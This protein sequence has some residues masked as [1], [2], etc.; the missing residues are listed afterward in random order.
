MH[1]IV[2]VVARAAIIGMWGCSAFAT[3]QGATPE[4]AAPPTFKPVKKG[5]AKAVSNVKP[6]LVEPF[7]VGSIRAPKL[8]VVHR[9]ETIM[10]VGI[11]V[12]S[13]GRKFVSYP[14][15]TDKGNW[16]LA[17][18]KDGKEVPYPSSGAFQMGHKNDPKTNLVS[19]Q[20]LI[21]DAQDRL[22]ILDT[23]TV[24]M[25]PVAP[26]SPKLVCI[27]TKTNT[28]T[29]TISFPE[30]VAPEGTYLN[31]LRIDGRRGEGEGIA[32]ITD[33]GVT[34]PNGIICVDLKSG[35][36][37]RR[38]AGHPSTQADPRFVGKPE[39]GPLY[40]R[41][42]PAV[43]SPVRIGSDGIAISPDGEF[44][45]YT[46]LSS[47]KLYR[48]KTAALSDTG[49]SDESVNRMV[50]D[51]G[52][53][54][55]ADGLEEDTDGRIYITDWEKQAITRRGTDGTIETIVKDDR[56]LWPDTLDMG[57]DGYLYILT[58]QLHRQPNYHGGKELRKPPYLLMRIKVDDAKPVILDGNKLPGVV[59]PGTATK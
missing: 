43:K 34:S 57:R 56:L 40:L 53:K 36:S 4:K 1:R 20:G 11:A 12:T 29:K 28:V 22:W 23:G 6:V 59:V 10:P 25:K 54:G 31:D 47:R 9:F 27:D 52:E 17:E 37:W 49:V 13:D 16:T 39:T 46:P 42:K 32:Y 5:T 33:S 14:R 51:L 15:W 21:T 45:Y 38:L 30:D 7:A 2:S 41:P 26:F 48:V 35:K 3:P 58:N 18:I 55:V 24:E 50:E 44:L 19:L 8:E